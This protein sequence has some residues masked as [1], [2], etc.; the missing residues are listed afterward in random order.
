MFFFSNK[1]AEI[2]D[3]SLTK[4]ND[5]EYDND[6]EEEDFEIETRLIKNGK[7]YKSLKTDPNRVERNKIHEFSLKKNDLFKKYQKFYLHYGACSLVW[8]IY[9]PI[10]IFI[11]SFISE[12]YRLRLVLSKFSFFLIINIK[13]YFELLKI[14]RYTIFC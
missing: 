6:L 9:L 8:F 12:L 3:N 14:K 10:L 4:T 7:T 5:D 1:K 13:N 11:T 2:N